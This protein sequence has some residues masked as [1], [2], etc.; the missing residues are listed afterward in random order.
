MPGALVYSSGR[1]SNV[2]EDMMLA[3]YKVYRAGLAKNILISGDHGTRYYDEVNAMK[4]VFLEPGALPED[5]FTDHTGFSTYES[6]YRARD[7]FGAKNLIIASQ[8]FHL[9]RS[10][11]IARGLGPE[12]QAYA[13]DRLEYADAAKNESREYLARI[14]AFLDVAILKPLPSFLGPPSPSQATGAQAGIKGLRARRRPSPR[15]PSPPSP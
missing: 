11:Y 4:R 7:V 14:K 15:T 12:A 8:A 10:L 3:A 2:V 6:L 1:V 9:P 5:L 13:A